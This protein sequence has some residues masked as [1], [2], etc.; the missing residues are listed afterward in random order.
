MTS[1]QKNY[2][3]SIYT[4]FT[5]LQKNSNISLLDTEV[6]R[7]NNK[8]VVVIIIDAYTKSLFFGRYFHTKLTFGFKNRV[9]CIV[10]HFTI[11]TTFTN[12]L[13]YLLKNLTENKECISLT[14]LQ[15]LSTKFDY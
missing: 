6:R 1:F 15:G 11:R 3:S 4:Q 8:N 14:F 9:A 5:I 2:P 12:H 10:L 13:K 7:S